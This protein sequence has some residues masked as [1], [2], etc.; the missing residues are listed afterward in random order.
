MNMAGVEADGQAV[1]VLHLINN[2]SNFFK[3]ASHLGAFTCHRLQCNLHFGLIRTAEHFI[4]AF[5]NSVDAV[6]SILIGIR[7]GME[8]DILHADRMRTANLL[9]QKLT[10]SSNVLGL[11]DPRLIMYGAWTT[12]SSMPLSC[13]AALPSS[14]NIE[15]IGLRR[16]FCGAPVYIMNE[17]EPYDVASAVAVSNPLSENDTGTNF[18][19]RIPFLTHNYTYFSL[20]IE[21]N[22]EMRYNSHESVM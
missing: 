18:Q 6:F 10:A 15:S 4:K 22:L 7:T 21:I 13:M 17:L 1:I 5:G 14:I 12:I 9:L 8:N 16:V 3:T 19:H 11:Y 20:Y 2:G